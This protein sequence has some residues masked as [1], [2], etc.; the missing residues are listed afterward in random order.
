MSHDQRFTQR[1]YGEIIDA[2]DKAFEVF[3]RESKND[4]TAEAAM[5]AF[6]LNHYFA[7]WRAM[8]TQ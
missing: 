5:R 3:K 1:D 8:A 6:V 7:V 2:L 4:L